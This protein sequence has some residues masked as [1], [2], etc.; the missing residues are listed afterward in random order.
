MV[1]LVDM[2]KEQFLE[3]GVSKEDGAMSLSPTNFSLYDPVV[4]TTFT[5]WVVQG[6][7]DSV[8]THT[9]FASLPEANKETII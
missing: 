8:H 4:S 2:V 3:A 9:V 6:S 1:F 5:D 7:A